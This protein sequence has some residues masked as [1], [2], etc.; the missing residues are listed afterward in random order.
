GAAG[1]LVLRPIPVAAATGGNMILGQANDA[2]APTTLAPT[3][4]STPSSLFEVIGQ[5]P[6]TIPTNPS[7]HEPS[8]SNVLTPITV[9]VLLAVSPYGIFPTTG[10]PTPTTVYPGV[11]PIQ[12]I[13]GTVSLGT[14]PN[15]VHISEGV[16]G[17][18]SVDVA[19]VKANGAGVV[20]TSDFGI[21]VVGA[22]GTDIAAFGTGYLA[23]T[24][25]T[26][27]NGILI[28]GP[29]PNPVYNFEQARDK[30]GVLWLS[31][32]SFVA[33]EAWRRMNTIIPVNPFRIYDS[34]P[35]ARPANS[36]TDIQI[37][38][39]N[40]IPS[41]AIGVFGNLTALGP[42]AD[43][44]LTM[45]PKG[46]TLGQTNSLTYSIGSP[47]DPPQ[48]MWFLAWSPFA[49]SHGHNPLFSTYIDYPAGFNLLWNCTFP[50]MAAILAPITAILGPVFSY[51]VLETLAVGL[52]A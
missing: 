12:G 7:N 48:M 20:G 10:P 4:A 37:A 18:A 17:F 35:T 23:Q 31:T 5:N 22:G 43:G 52:S 41:D 34:R 13:G 3:A 29:P 26:D 11:A 32:A 50:L 30:D 8:G 16:D 6:P 36:S 44:F 28:S 46:Q 21:G 24:S 47:G 39:V 49:L 38:G 42:A 45:I 40:G 1:G 27:S 2:N 51:N 9:P 14:S 25:I 19:D 15:N 33:G